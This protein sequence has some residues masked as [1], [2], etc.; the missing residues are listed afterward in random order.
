VSNGKPLDC[1]FLVFGIDDL[2]KSYSAFK[3]S[4]HEDRSLRRACV[5]AEE[6]KQDQPVAIGEPSAVSA[7]VFDAALATAIQ[8]SVSRDKPMDGLGDFLQSTEPSRTT[9]VEKRLIEL[10]NSLRDQSIGGKLTVASARY[11]SPFQLY[12]P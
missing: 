10:L 8:S 9:E 3:I 12:N 2:A 5:H 6:V 7:I 1:E 4:A 11:E